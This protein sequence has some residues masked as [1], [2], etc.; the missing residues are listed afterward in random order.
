MTEQDEAFLEWVEGYEDWYDT[1]SGRWYAL[2]NTCKILT[3]IAS[4]VSIVASALMDK[5]YFGGAG[6]WVLVGAAVV[7]AAASEILGQLKVREKEDLREMGRIEAERVTSYARQ[8][9]SEF[10][11]DPEKL[12]AVKNEI[13]ELIHKPELSQH[14]GATSIDDGKPPQTQH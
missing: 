8:K 9:L 10:E 11:N 12:A 1:S 3:L 7:T 4:L 6:R 5:D 2:L 13:R 14:R